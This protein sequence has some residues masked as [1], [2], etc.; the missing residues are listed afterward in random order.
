M[1]EVEE[2]REILKRLEPQP[3]WSEGSRSLVMRL[4]GI[5]AVGPNAMRM[6]PDDNPEF[7]WRNFGPV[8]PIQFEAA[9]RIQQLEE[10]LHRY[11]VRYFSDECD[12][13]GIN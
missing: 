9:A 2:L 7:G 5:Y 10:E 6:G 11:R 13:R 8:P 3:H 1:S 12:R 4:R